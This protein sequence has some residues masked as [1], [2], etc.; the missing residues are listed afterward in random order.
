MND[1]SVEVGESSL[2]GKELL[3]ALSRTGEFVFHGSPQKLDKLEPRQQMHFNPKTGKSE[4]DGSPAVCASPDYEIAIFRSLTSSHIARQLGV[5]NYYTEFGLRD[6]KPYFR[7]T[8]ESIAL[9]RRPE[10][11]GYVHV[12]SKKGFQSHNDLENRAYHQVEPLYIVEVKS[13]DLPE[14]IEI[15]QRPT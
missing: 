4:S 3:E 8:A 2:N 14:N 6:G 12:F 9:A 11:V 15:I 10:A 13:P 7:G 1:C 5:K